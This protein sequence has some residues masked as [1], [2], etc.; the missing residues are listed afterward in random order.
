MTII[1]AIHDAAKNETWLGCNDRATIG[2]TP[3]P[4]P[5]SKWLKFGDWAIGLSGDE[6]V[7]V[8]YL[9]LSEEKFPAEAK[10]VL[11]I[12][13]FL[14]ATYEHYSLGQQKGNDTSNSYGVD[15]I[16]VHASGRMWDFDNN[17]ALS[18]VPADCVWGCGS[19]VDYALGADHVMAAQKSFTARERINN[20]LKA[21]IALD[22]G[23]PGDPLIEAFH[24]R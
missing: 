24:S 23:C 4:G 17:L 15:G 7:Y 21:A 20:A 9:Q 8:Q 11:E 19:G 10:T 22:I 18:E 2:D 16:L 12:F 3:A 14:R 6:C 13:E 5:A 1:C